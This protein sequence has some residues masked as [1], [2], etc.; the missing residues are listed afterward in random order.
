M[1]PSL[2][3]LLG[4]ESHKDKYLLYTLVFM[5]HCVLT[6]AN[7]KHFHM[8]ERR[9]EKNEITGLALGIG[10]IANRVWHHHVQ[11]KTQR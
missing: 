1:I 7:L 3:P 5:L 2:V 4:N 9:K 11:G 8:R 10:H 6:F